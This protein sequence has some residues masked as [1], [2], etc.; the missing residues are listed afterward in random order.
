[1]APNK[2]QVITLGTKLKILTEVDKNNSYSQIG[3]KFGLSK[4]TIS[5]IVSNRKKIEESVC[6]TKRK[7]IRCGKFKNVEDA[8][9]K[10][11]KMMRSKNIAI[12]GTLVKTKAE[13]F[14]T[15]L[16]VD[17]FRATNGWLDR[18]KIRNDI[19]FKLIV[20]EKADAPM[21]VA[22][23]WIEN[24]LPNLI[25]SFELRNIFNLDETGL[26]YKLTPNKTLAFNNDSCTGGKNSKE[27]VSLLIGA[28]ADGSEKLPL[29]M[30][31][32]SAKPRC[33]N[34]VKSLPLKYV[35]NRK[36]WMTSTIW[37][38][39]L[40]NLDKKFKEENRSVVF[41]ADNCPS[42]TNVTGLK[43]I[44]LIFLPPNI[45]AICQPMD[46]GVIKN[47]KHFYKQL[48][49]IKIINDL[50]SSPESTMKNVKITLLDAANFISKSWEKVKS[51]TI[52]NCF[53]KAGI[54]SNEPIDATND[55]LPEIDNLWHNPTIQTTIEQS[56][57]I[58]LK[59][60]LNADD[61]LTTDATNS[62]D[63]IIAGILDA[64]R[65]DEPESD[66]EIVVM[67]SVP[68]NAD[69]ANA[70]RCIQTFLNYS[71]GTEVELQKLQQIEIKVENLIQISL[72]QQKITDYFSAS[73]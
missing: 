60:Y 58:S 16:K 18:F 48:L 63:E 62:D 67:P 68:T 5:T 3:I 70:F 66:D 10:W 38:D 55:N 73:K 50:E 32:K 14:A 12:S 52:S 69:I 21:E 20:G 26:F 31:G 71:E 23:D 53:K 51:T 61:D 35:S 2:R 43:S 45:T 41:I 44:K 33:F 54:N 64:P 34:N 37:E 49:L 11:V 28:N 65:S 13:Y 8:V 72:K 17:D 15:L 42:H 56:D 4:T 7:K 30:I 57:R 27:R 39:Y 59:E 47:I 22:N 29:L 19:T 25:Q 24:K 1:M 6:S 9:V 46:Q 36:S 40:L